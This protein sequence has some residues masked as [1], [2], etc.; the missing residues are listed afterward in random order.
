[1]KATSSRKTARQQE[2]ILLVKDRMSTFNRQ[3]EK[4]TIVLKGMLVGGIIGVI[5]LVIPIFPNC[6]T[7][8]WPY[9]APEG[10][11]CN[12]ADTNMTLGLP[13][14]YYLQVT[15]RYHNTTTA[16]H[17]YGRTLGRGSGSRIIILDLIFWMSLSTLGVWIYTRTK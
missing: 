5:M 12:T 9:E 1:M 3:R 10:A 7:K 17:T 8:V 11:S 16:E 13:L 6:D 15:H 2:A 4:Q 14:P